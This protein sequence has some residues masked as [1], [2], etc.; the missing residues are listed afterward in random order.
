MDKRTIA[1]GAA[2]LLVTILLL[3]VDI[4][5]AGIAFIILAV[6]VMSLLIMGDSAFLPQI[7]V[8]LRDDAKAIVLTNN[9]NSA[10]LGIHV[11][12]VPMNIEYDIPSLAVE[13]SHEFPL[14]SMLAEVKVVVTFS[15]ENGQP[16]SHSRNLSAT[17][18]EFEPLKPMVPVFGWK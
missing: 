6:I 4:Y 5:L 16:F 3:F 7:A 8:R 17:G 14:S 1:I 10:A 12:L 15:N 9:G 2:G 11:A 18:E 13:E